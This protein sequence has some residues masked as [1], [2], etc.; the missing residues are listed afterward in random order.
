MNEVV[1][2]SPT[3]AET[4]CWRAGRGDNLKEIRTIE[5]TMKHKKNP[6]DD[7][8]MWLHYFT[9]MVAMMTEISYSTYQLVKQMCP[10]RDPGRN[11]Q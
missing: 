9:S 2:K 10:K 4:T 5:T 11:C 6:N 7:N 8:Q 3:P 1:N